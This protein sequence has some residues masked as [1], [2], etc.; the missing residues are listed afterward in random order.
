K[1]IVKGRVGQTTLK[2]A[3]LTPRCEDHLA[4]EGSQAAPTIC[5]HG[6]FRHEHETVAALEEIGRQSHGTIQPHA[7]VKPCID[8]VGAEF[9]EEEITIDLES[10]RGTPGK[11]REW[12]AG[13]PLSVSPF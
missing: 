11:Y 6:W 8:V 5:K 13:L 9:A 7:G 12:S 2:K 1:K 10:S 3:I 4:A